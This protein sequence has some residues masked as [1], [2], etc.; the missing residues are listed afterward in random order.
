MKKYVA[1][2]VT[3]LLITGG[4]ALTTTPALADEGDDVATTTEVSSYGYGYPNPS[5]PD[6]V[7]EYGDWEVSSYDCKSELQTLTREVWTQDWVWDGYSG[8][9]VAGEQT[10]TTEETT[11]PTTDEQCPPVIPPKPEPKVTYGEWVVGEPD[12]ELGQVT[13]TRV[14][15]TT[16]W[17]WNGEEWVEGATTVTDTQTETEPA[18]DEQ[19]EPVTPPKPEPKVTVGEWKK[20]EPDCQFGEVES[21]RTT[22]TTDWVWDDENGEWVEGETTETTETKTEAVTEEDCY[23]P[24]APEPTTTPVPAKASTP[25]TPAASSGLAQTG[26]ETSLWLLPAAGLALL[27]GLGAVIRARAARR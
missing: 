15:Y 6:V 4:L 14:V 16:D 13:K 11:E 22:Y 23:V 1:A 12:C 26:G 3:A 27:A 20:G 19:C 8:Q 21:T 17:E 24:P 18:T 7:V 2:S 25:V 10:S 9:W 5:K